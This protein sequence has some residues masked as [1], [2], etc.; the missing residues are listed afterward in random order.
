MPDETKFKCTLI[1]ALALVCG[2]GEEDLPK[3]NDIF[4]AQFGDDNFLT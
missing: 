4:R 2:E 1:A 3:G